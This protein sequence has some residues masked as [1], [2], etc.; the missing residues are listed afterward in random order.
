MIFKIVTF[1]AIQCDNSS[2]KKKTTDLS[3]NF[4]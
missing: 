1:G 4:G 3:F 2:A